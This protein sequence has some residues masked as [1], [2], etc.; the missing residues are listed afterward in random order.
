MKKLENLI[1]ARAVSHGLCRTIEAAKAKASWDGQEFDLINLPMVVSC[2]GCEM[3]MGAFSA[4]IDNR[5][6]FF[7]QDCVEEDERVSAVRD[8]L[9]AD[10]AFE[11]ER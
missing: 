6:V 4:W 3:T 5:G 2:G 7:C 1:Y 10:E 8:D 11:L 9:E